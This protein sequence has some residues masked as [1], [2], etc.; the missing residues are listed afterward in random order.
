LTKD[1]GADIILAD[2]TL[3]AL[4]GGRM[5]TIVSLT[6]DFGNKDSFAGGMKG[7]LLNVN[8][9]A[10]IV[11]ISH[12]VGPQDIWEAAFTLKTAYSYFPKGTVHVAVVDPGVGSGRRPILAVT[13]SYYFVGPDNGIFSLIFLEAERL[14]VYHITASHY[15]LPDPGPTF[16]GRHIFA[17]V[18]AW[19][20]KG[21]PP[22]NFGEKIED[23][24]KLN[25]P[26]SKKS[27]NVIDGNIIHI[28][29]FGNLIIN[30]TFNDIKSLFPEGAGIGAL[31]VAVSGKE[32]KG[33]SKYYSEAAPG[34]PGAIINSSGYLEIFLFKQ[35]ARTALSAK[36]GEAVK[37]AVLPQ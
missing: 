24:V 32:I 26:M 21:I 6:T 18:A 20:T 36:R 5:S 34:Q 4:I 25:V 35:N 31:S 14:E 2:I 12:E 11:D 22:V 3:I 10:Q 1:I 30:I 19:L 13:E 23:F 17:P 37:L 27:P 16:H 29:R 28:D 15:F 8:P 33:L 9:L 7:A